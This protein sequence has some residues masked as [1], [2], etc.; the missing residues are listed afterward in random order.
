MFVLLGKTSKGEK[1]YKNVFT[2]KTGKLP[3]GSPIK[4]GR[5]PAGILGRFIHPAPTAIQRAMFKGGL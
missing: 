1:V 5:I 3:I 4:P 2:K